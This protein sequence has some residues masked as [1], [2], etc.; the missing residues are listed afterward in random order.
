MDKTITFTVPA[1]GI[2]LNLVERII[3]RSLVIVIRRGL[4]SLN[5]RTDP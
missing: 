1:I 2:L 3:V 4:K 5:G